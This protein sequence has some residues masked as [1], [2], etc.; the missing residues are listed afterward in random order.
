MS[1]GSATLY[2]SGVLSASDA[3]RLRRV[4]VA[5]PERVRTLRLDLHGVTSLE[6]GAMDAVRAVVRYWRETRQGS[7]RLS[8]ATEH[9]LATIREGDAVPAQ[10]QGVETLAP[11]PGGRSP[12][13]MGT[14]L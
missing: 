8:F 13:L 4:C 10:V 7:F 3:F 14:F 11:Y 9:I 12:A 2:I 1:G 5:V 6:E